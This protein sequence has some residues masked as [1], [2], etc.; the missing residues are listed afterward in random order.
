MGFGLRKI[1]L[2]ALSTTVL[3]PLP[4]AIAQD[5]TETTDAEARRFQTVNVTAQRREQSQLDVPLSVS[6]FDGDLL[7]DLGVADITEVAKIS[8]NVTLEV[9]WHKLHPHRFHSRCRPTRPGCGFRSWR[10]NLSR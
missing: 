2:V 5:T 10:W 1:A 9:A 7:A 3:S 6:A 8:P 4:A